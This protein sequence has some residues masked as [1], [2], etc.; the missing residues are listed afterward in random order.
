MW[1]F[2]SMTLN[3]PG[4]KITDPITGETTIS[5]SEQ[6]VAEG[7][8]VPASAK[9]IDKGFQI[10]SYKCYCNLPEEPVVGNHTVSKD[11][12]TYSIDS[13]TYWPQ[14]DLYILELRK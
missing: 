4:T 10:G 7:I 6:L 5:G 14:K 3:T 2:E 9:D 12:Q 8:I 11:N 1:K 13:F